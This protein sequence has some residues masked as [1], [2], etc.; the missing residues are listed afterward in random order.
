MV[1]GEKA[2]QPFVNTPVVD[3]RD[4]GT[5]RGWEKDTEGFGENF[6]YLKWEF[7]EC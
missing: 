1:C 7:A 6:V 2:W 3:G 4:T 5:L